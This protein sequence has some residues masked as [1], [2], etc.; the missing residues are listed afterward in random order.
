MSVFQDGA[1]K[2]QGQA[3]DPEI[4]EDK[5]QWNHAFCEEALELLQACGWTFEQVVQMAVYVF[6]RPIG[7]VDQEIGGVM[8]VLAGLSHGHGLDMMTCATVELSNANLPGVAEKVRAKK[9]AKPKML[10]FAASKAEEPDPGPPVN[11]IAGVNFTVS[12]GHDFDGVTINGRH[13]DVTH[14]ASRKVPRTSDRN[15]E[16]RL[17]AEIVQELWEARKQNG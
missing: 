15:T 16:E 6:N 12:H 7:K 14:H 1:V 4:I 3:F 8:M 9:S 5:D 2:W 11:F 13:S 10:A 17:Q